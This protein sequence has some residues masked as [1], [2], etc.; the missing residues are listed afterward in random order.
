MAGESVAMAAIA[1]VYR[2]G[3]KD[4]GQRRQVGI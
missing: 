1:Y 3:K 2:D 4:L